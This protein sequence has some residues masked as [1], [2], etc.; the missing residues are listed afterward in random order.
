LE[1]NYPGGARGGSPGAGN[2]EGLEKI[3]PYSLG[4]NQFN[5]LVPRCDLCLTVSG[6]ATLHAAV[7]G[8]PQIVVYRLNPLYWHLFGRWV[9]KTRTYSLV[10]LLND[11]R[12][13]IVPEYIPWYGSN[14]PLAEKALEYLRNPEMLSEQ[15]D[16]LR[17][18]IRGLN[19]PG[20]SR[21]VAR[22]ANDLMLGR[23]E[24]VKQSV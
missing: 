11:S 22:L 15:R 5:Q 7:H 6:T 2:G 16:R 14:Q 10:N 13:N 24:T 9:V 8:S 20:A 21:N 4:L 23:A 19:R 17:N 1:A 3:G 18:L 12:Q